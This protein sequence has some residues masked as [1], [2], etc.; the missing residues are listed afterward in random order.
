[1]FGSRVE[2]DHV[3]YLAKKEEIAVK[4]NTLLLIFKKY[5]HDMDKQNVFGELV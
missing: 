1:M 4:V 5:A 3:N 2:Q